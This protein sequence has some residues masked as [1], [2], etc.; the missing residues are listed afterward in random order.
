MQSHRTVSRVSE[1]SLSNKP[2]CLFATG[3]L[4]VVLFTD[5]VPKIESSS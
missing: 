5:V 1:E 4:Y 2:G 3:S